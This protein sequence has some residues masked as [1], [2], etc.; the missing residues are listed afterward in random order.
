MKLKDLIDEGVLADARKIDSFAKEHGKSIPSVENTLRLVRDIDTDRLRTVGQ[1]VWGVGGEGGAN[2]VGKSFDACVAELSK[3]NEQSAAWTG[4]ANNAYVK[5]VNKTKGAITGME[6][7][8]KDVGKSLVAIADAWD[9]IFGSSFAD[10]L[11]I[12][13]L[14]LSIIGVIV[15]VIVEIVAGWT[16]IGAVIG[17]II[18]VLSILV[19]AVS[20]WWT[21]HSNEQAKIE[22]LTEA[23]V[24][25]TETMNSANTSAP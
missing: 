9:Q 14:A 17:L 11:A 23:S 25:A 1:D 6:D 24:Q 20:I 13:G 10:I 12:I 7:P 21:M 5:R 2:L 18:G 15:A 16:G 8:A 22:A 4:D 19:G 3:A